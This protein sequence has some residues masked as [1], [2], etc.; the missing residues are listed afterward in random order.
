MKKVSKKIRNGII[1]RF[2]ASANELPHSIEYSHTEG[3]WKIFKCE[4][5]KNTMR[6]AYKI[7]H[8][9]EFIKWD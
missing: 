8:S 9:I 5:A 6:I 7:T 3:G 1:D 2:F 4:S